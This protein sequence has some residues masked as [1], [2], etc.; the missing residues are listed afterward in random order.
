MTRMRDNMPAIIIFLVIAFILTIVFEW[1]MDYLGIT[2]PKYDSV[3]KVNGKK[4]DYT[5][6]VELVKQRSENQKAQ[7]GKE[8]DE[9]QLVQIREEVWN[10]LVTQL[11]I[12]EEIAK[13]GIEVPDQEIVDWVHGENPPEFLTRQFMDSLGNFNRA[14]YES[15]ISDPRNKE[16]WV[17]VEAGLRKQ[18]MQEKLQSVLLAGVRVSDSEMLQRFTDQN[19]KFNIDY[20]LFDPNQFIKDEETNVTDSDIEK[21]YNEHSTEFKVEATRKLKYVRFM[22]APSAKDTQSVISEMEGILHRAQAGADFKD[23]ANTYS[24]APASDVF[25]KPGELSPIKEEQLFSAKVGSIVGPVKDQDGYHLIKILEEKTGTDE[26][27]RASH[28]LISTQG[29]DSVKALA[30]AKNILARIRKGENFAELAKLHSQDP[31]SGAK[32]GDLGWFGKGRMAKPFEDASYKTGINQIVGPIRTQFG[33]HIIKVTG[34]TKREIK[35]API[36]MP[37]KAS[38]QTRN[39]IYQNAQDFEFL[40]KE[41]DFVK[42]AEIA[43]YEVLETLPFTEKGTIPG[44]GL[45][46]SINR[47]AFEEKVGDISEVL[48]ITEGYAVFIITEAKKEGIRPLRELEETLRPRVL[49]EKKMQLL[50]VKVEEFRKQIPN[51]E[52]LRTLG[53][54]HPEWIISN[55]GSFTPAG[56]IPGIGRDLMLIGSVQALNVGD[57]SKPIEG[58]RGYYI[59]KILEKG[60]IDS[61]AYKAQKEIL[62][63]Q[64]LQGKKNQFL[65]D[66][67]EQLKKKADIEDNRDIFFR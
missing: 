3:G 33:Y 55:S 9:N 40:A 56:G 37:V 43:K 6:F 66:W 49:R 46:R 61:T 1:G 50:K 19:L 51:K 25:Y 62:V 15:A 35:I 67:L 12:D 64:I 28:I 17:Q 57:I 2:Q 45:H 14:A 32:G 7:S 11:L 42:E 48:A 27:I 59:V 20:V 16:I 54:K 34:K 52:D 4:I 44:I 31:G 29:A 47:F 21:Y 10:S 60:T 26:F 13:M 5:E 63:T 30:E 65:S 58:M 18:R 38:S 39:E 41:N 53:A 23:L 36:S 8:P 22:D 24:E